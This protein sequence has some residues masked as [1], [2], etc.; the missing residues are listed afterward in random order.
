MSSLPQLRADINALQKQLTE[1]RARIAELES[2]PET[3]R[4]VMV[5]FETVR[6]EYIDRA[7]ID[8]VKYVDN[9][10]HLATIAALQSIIRGRE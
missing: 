7:P 6:V 8:V 3:V 10:D 4:E 2:M 9:P 5:P 1:A